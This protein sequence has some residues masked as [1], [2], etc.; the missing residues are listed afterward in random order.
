MLTP[1][2]WGLLEGLLDTPP[3]SLRAL[4]RKVERDVRGVHADVHRLLRCGLV[5]R[6]N[7][8]KLRLFGNYDAEPEYGIRAN[9]ITQIHVDFTVRSTEGKKR[10]ER[11]DHRRPH[12]LDL[13][14]RSTA[15]CRGRCEL[16]R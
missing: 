11:S 15:F 3:L 12:R 1:N 4:A 2:R 10:H 16:R 14:P 7:A 13:G 6:T 5:E 8:G 9:R